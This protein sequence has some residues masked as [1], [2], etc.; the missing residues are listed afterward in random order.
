M[1]F[2]RLFEI[3]YDH[4]RVYGLD[5]LRATA[6]LF[7]MLLHSTY[8]LPDKAARV[9]ECLSLDGVSIF[10]VLSGYLIGAILIREFEKRQPTA[11]TLFHFWFRRWMRTLPAYYF[12]LVLL[13]L[14]PASYTHFQ[15]AQQT[16]SYLLFLQNL[17]KPHPAFFMEA[18]SLSIEEWFYLVVPALLFVLMLLFK[19]N[20]RQGV[21]VIASST[22]IFAL[23]Y[24][25]Y[26]FGKLDI[27][28]I[29]VWDETFRKQVLSRPDSI[30]VGVIG[31]Y[32]S[33]YRKEL[34][35]RHKAAL[36]ALGITILIALK[37]AFEM[38]WAEWKFFFSTAYFTVSAIGVLCMLPFLSGLKT[39]QG[40]THKFLTYIS[41]ISYSMY[42]LNLSFIQAFLLPQIDFHTYRGNLVLHYVLFWVLTIGAAAL[43]Y[44]FVERPF[45]N[46]REKRRV[47][48]GVTEE[49]VSAG[50]P[51]QEALP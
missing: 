37:L 23:V 31:A 13:I 32:M 35:N 46:L 51:A 18:W 48:H 34:W 14:L 44:K 8:L 19:S 6:I 25:G 36:L 29:K 3:K 47:Q 33:C 28:T 41:I 9:L 30:M 42:L 26:L 50:V 21:I 2:F 17:H 49:P 20:P 40:R 39:S 24:R 7:V 27:P 45:M 16:T 4:S 22:I 11:K 15:S 12:T 5:I 43:L 10:F 38:H 1:Q